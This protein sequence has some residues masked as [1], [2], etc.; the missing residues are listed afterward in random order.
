MPTLESNDQGFNPQKCN[1]DLSPANRPDKWLFFEG[2]SLGSPSLN[3]RCG[4]RA[5]WA[6]GKLYIY[7]YLY[8]IKVYIS[9]FLTRQL[10]VLSAY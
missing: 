8:I 6:L 4:L 2:A 3:W 10:V 7:I 1:I 9:S 5:A